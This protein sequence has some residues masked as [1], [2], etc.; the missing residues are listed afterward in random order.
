MKTQI[1]IIAGT[2]LMLTGQV[3]GVEIRQDLYCYPLPLTHPVLFHIHQ[4]FVITNQPSL[5]IKPAKY[6]PDD[7]PFI[8]TPA[9]VFTPTVFFALNSAWLSPGERERLLKEMR[10]HQIAIPLQVSGYTCEL[11]SEP[12][13]Q[14][15][16][17]HRAETVAALLR[18]HGYTVATV[19]GKGMLLGNDLDKNRRVEIKPVTTHNNVQTP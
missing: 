6:Q 15:I 13:N 8:D 2:F 9:I 5:K 14:L 1:I 3:W 19:E 11:G 16:S 18:A 12:Q 10:P 17:R 4:S 7:W